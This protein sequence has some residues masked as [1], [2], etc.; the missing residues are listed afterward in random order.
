MSAKSFEFEKVNEFVSIAAPADDVWKK[1]REFGCMGWHPAVDSTEAHDGNQAGSIRTLRLKG[2]ANILEKLDGHSDESRSYTYRM[3]DS[4]P[5]PIHDYSSTIRV[6]E[7]GIMSCQVEWSGSFAS[8]ND[9]GM[10]VEIIT[11]IYQAGLS[12]LKSQ[13]E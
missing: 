13:L 11:G 12:H 2:G 10:A 1:L 6:R 8:S 4:G 9:D 3:L 5:L 7:A